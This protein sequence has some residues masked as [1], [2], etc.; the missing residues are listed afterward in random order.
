MTDA[1]S[2]VAG[3]RVR[4][5]DAGT[6]PYSPAGRDNAPNAGDETG[7]S[8]RTYLLTFLVGLAFFGVNESFI[9]G[10]SALYTDFAV[11]ANFDEIGVHYVRGLPTFPFHHA[12]GALGPIAAAFVVR[13]GNRVGEL[14]R[15]PDVCHRLF[16]IVGASLFRGERDTL[17]CRNANAPLQLMIPD[18]CREP[19]LVSSHTPERRG[20]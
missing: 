15:S 1:A 3:D 17:N 20:D 12:P 13:K 2:G 6:S 8:R 7:F 10:D 18:G 5:Q 9:L 16:A 4:A 19:A 11:N 14:P